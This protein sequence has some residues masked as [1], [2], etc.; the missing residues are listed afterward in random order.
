MLLV[1]QRDLEPRMFGGC[2]VNQ[3]GEDRPGRFQ[4]QCLWSTDL[5]RIDTTVGLWG[6]F[7]DE[8]TSR[9]DQHH[10][11][12]RMALSGGD[13]DI[14]MSKAEPYCLPMGLHSWWWIF[15]LLELTAVVTVFHWYQNPASL[16]FQC[17]LE[18]KAS[19]NLQHFQFYTETG[20]NQL[21]GPGS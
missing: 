12:D 9:M 11:L 13:P 3:T 8:S 19:R 2:K 7:Q 17:G 15:P 16:R 20:E 1:P 4:S 18:T 14:K 5:G 21:H 10:C 6:H